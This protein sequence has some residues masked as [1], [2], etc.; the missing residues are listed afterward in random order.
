M[1][2]LQSDRIGYA[3]AN[4]FVSAGCLFA[5]EAI[6]VYCKV[7]EF[8]QILNEVTVTVTHLDEES[9]TSISTTT[10]STSPSPPPPPSYSAEVDLP[11]T[12]QEVMEHKAREERQQHEGATGQFET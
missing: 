4:L 7:L 6:A 11:P 12:Y 3:S 9:P 5:V 1:G 2:T 8:G 10:S